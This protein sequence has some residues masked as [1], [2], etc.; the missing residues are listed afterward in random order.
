MDSKG[1][2]SKMQEKRKEEIPTKEAN[3]E[4]GKGRKR[5]KEMKISNKEKYVS[6]N[7]VSLNKAEKEM[8]KEHLI[9]RKRKAQTTVEK[10]GKGRRCEGSFTKKTLT[11]RR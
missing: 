5:K 6:L 10:K 8:W 11:K 3:K 1:F 7:K 2:K 4:K 9:K